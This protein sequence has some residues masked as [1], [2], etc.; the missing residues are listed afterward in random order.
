MGQGSCSGIALIQ[1]YGVKAGDRVACAMRNQP[2]WC[3]AFMAVTS[4]GAVIVPTNSLWKREELEYGLTDSGSKVLICDDLIF[5]RIDASLDKLGVRAIVSRPA[6]VLPAGVE[7]VHTVIERYQGMECP[8][9][10]AGHDDIGIIMYT[11]G[12]TGNPKGVV[13]SHRGICQNLVHFMSTSFFKRKS[14]EASRK[15]GTAPTQDCT[16]CPVPL[17]HVTASHQIFLAAITN[18]TKIVLM[19]KWDAGEALKLIGR[20]RPTSWAG[21]PTMVRD[22]IEHPNFEST[23]TSSLKSLLGGGAPTPTSQSALVAKKFKKG[24]PGQGYGLTETNG[25]VA[26]NFGASYLKNPGSTGKPNRIMEVAIMDTET[27]KRLWEPL[28][29]G[30]LLIRSPQNFTHYWNN[31][32]AT[33]EAIVE[34][35]GSGYGWFCS[36][37]LCEL[38]A[39]GAIYIKDRAKDIII[40]GGENISCAEVESAFFA[41][42]PNLMEC[43]CFGI[44][45]ERLGEV[46]GLMVYMKTGEPEDVA[47]LIQNVSGQIAPFKI[48]LAENFFFSK[49]PLPRGNTGK[50]LKRAIRDEINKEL[51][52]GKRVTHRSKL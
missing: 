25:A 40:R 4:I 43:A 34:L 21:V 36:G 50:T 7:A 13:Q 14:E 16:I 35:D 8:P 42:N 18:G 20:E 41:G 19:E 6:N 30:E 10:L 51:A 32:K 27:G 52:E 33:D 2:E 31:E 15:L 11:S 49:E 28:Q 9:C 47:M 23:D 44:K 38:D 12:T 22:L 24:T 26:V 3:I 1:D 46:V 5:G 48:P 39:E 37:D 45:D 29:Q 17:F